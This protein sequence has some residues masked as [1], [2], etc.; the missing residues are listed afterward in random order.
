MSRKGFT[1]IRFNRD[2]VEQIRRQADKPG[3]PS[4][5]VL[6][7]MYT[8]SEALIEQILDGVYK[9]REWYEEQRQVICTRCGILVFPGNAMYG[10][11][12][13]KYAASLYHCKPCHAICERNK[14]RR[15]RRLAKAQG[16]TRRRDFVKMFVAE[17]MAQL[18]RNKPAITPVDFQASIPG[19]TEDAKRLWRKHRQ[20]IATQTIEQIRVT[21]GFA[22]P[23]AKLPVDPERVDESGIER[24]W[25]PMI[26]E[27]VPYGT[28]RKLGPFIRKR[29]LDTVVRICQAYMKAHPNADPDHLF[30]VHRIRVNDGPWHDDVDNPIPFDLG[31]KKEGVA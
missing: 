8:V 7:E 14:V 3:G 22:A 10:D 25:T 31:E 13:D 11:H 24:A 20:E 17:S 2:E 29:N 5:K 19:F 18:K 15:M 27:N 1:R 26:Y 28:L 9:S 23:V 4:N 12:S 30:L 16:R 21:L 6:A